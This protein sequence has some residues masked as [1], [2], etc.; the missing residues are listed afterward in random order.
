MSVIEILFNHVWNWRSWSFSVV[1]CECRSHPFCGLLQCPMVFTI[2]RRERRVINVHYQCELIT[3]MRT[4]FVL[5]SDSSQPRVTLHLSA[6]LVIEQYVISEFG[7]QKD[8]GSRYAHLW[9][10]GPCFPLHCARRSEHKKSEF[11]AFRHCEDSGTRP[12]SGE[13]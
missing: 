8:L 1:E 7:L 10:I 5:K 3:T 12:R 6:L 11:N 13:N 2:I 9:V 4:C